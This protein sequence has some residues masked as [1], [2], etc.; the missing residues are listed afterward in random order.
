MRSQQDIKMGLELI[1]KHNLTKRKT[2]RVKLSRPSQTEVIKKNARG[3]IMFFTGEKIMKKSYEQNEKYQ[4]SVKQ[5]NQQ[6]EKQM[7]ICC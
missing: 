4:W 7:I 2:P 6:L 1:P 5:G 3:K